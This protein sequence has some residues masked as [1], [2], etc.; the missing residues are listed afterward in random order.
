MGKKEKKE[1]KKEEKGK[2]IGVNSIIGGKQCED[3]IFRKTVRLIVHHTSHASI[4][5]ERVGY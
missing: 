2:Q 5:C 3:V 1:R 4:P